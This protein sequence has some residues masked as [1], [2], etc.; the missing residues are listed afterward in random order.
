MGVGGEWSGTYEWLV[1]APCPLKTEETVSHRQS[2]NVVKEV[3][4]PA[5]AKQL[6]YFATGSFNSCVKH[7]LRDTKS[8]GPAVGTCC[9]RQSNSL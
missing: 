2:N 8:E 3:G 1:P 9:K 5:S 4:N 6:V 7:S